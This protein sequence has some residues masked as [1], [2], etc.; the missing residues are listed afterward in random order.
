MESFPFETTVPVRFSDLDPMG[1]VN[2]A[3]YATYCEQGRVAFFSEVFDVREA[4]GF[5]FILA[6]LE[7]DFRRPVLM[8]DP[9]RV[10]LRISSVGTTSFAFEYRLTVRGE[11]VAE[12]RSVQVFY[13]YRRHAKVAI[14][15]FFRERV[16][17]YLSPGV[18]C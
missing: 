7:I 18:S 2:N 9:L 12:A 16:R 5:E 14:P 1:H 11:V 4:A 6:R 10:G 3:V 15:D 13:D 17:P 8:D